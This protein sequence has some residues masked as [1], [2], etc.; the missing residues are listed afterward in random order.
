MSRRPLVDTVQMMLQVPRGIDGIWAA[1]RQLDQSGAWTIARAAKHAGVH[2]RILNEFA[3][4]LEAGGLAK[5]V[6]EEPAKRGGFS[7]TLYR[8]TRQPQVTPRL[9]RD[10]QPLPEAPT[11][12]LWRSMKIAKVFTAVEL[13]EL[14]SVKLSTT[15]AYLR[16]LAQAGVVAG[17]GNGGPEHFRLVLNLGARP[18]KILQAQ[19]VFDPNA[20]AVVGQSMAREVK[21]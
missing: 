15:R 14:A 18:P 6:G 10:G 1:V 7:A 20:K 3:R 13:A 21:S 5:R 12:V 19:V 17:A 9:A 16:A 4:G 11:D 2:E 8:L